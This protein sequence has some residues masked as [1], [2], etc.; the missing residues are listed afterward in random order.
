MDEENED[1]EDIPEYE[2]E[3]YFIGSLGLSMDERKDFFENLANVL[4]NLG[5]SYT[6][7]IAKKYYDFLIKSKKNYK[8]ANKE[9]EKEILFSN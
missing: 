6:R 4:R 1:F 3:E 7:H 2:K 9:L 8:K 5:V